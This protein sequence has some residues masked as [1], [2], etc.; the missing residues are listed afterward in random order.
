VSVQVKNL[1]K[2]FGEQVAV[3]AINFEIGEGEIVGFLGP[4]GAGKSTTM[5]M[6]TG[7]LPPTSGESWVAGFNVEKYPLDVKRNVGYLPEHNPLYLDLYVKEYLLFCAGIFKLDNKNERVKNIIERVG[8]T[9]EYKKKIGQLSKGY[10]Q[11]VGLAQALLHDPRVLVLDEPTSGLDP[12]Q[13]V[14]I[15]NVIKEFGQNKT[16]ILSTHIMQ[17]VQALCDKVIILNKGIIVANDKVSNLQTSSKT[18]TLI[19]LQTNKEIDLKPLKD[20]PGVIN[21]RRIGASKYELECTSDIREQ[22]FFA[23]AQAGIAIINMN[24]E[25]QSL[26]EIFKILTNPNLNV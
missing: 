1:K 12:N 9:P 14:E 16:V 13:I 10:R 25:Q 19:I 8:L 21:A 18:K 4:N 26:E 20:V 3:N 5:K 22:L 7:F 15:R 2:V 6:L 11:R 23:V 17:E 24:L